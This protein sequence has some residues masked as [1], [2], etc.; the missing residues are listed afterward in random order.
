MKKY[1]ILILFTFPLVS[2]EDFLKEEM[3]STITQDYFESEK[4]LE[5]L[6]VGSYNTL[7]WKY[8][9]MEGPFMFETGIDIAEP[10]DNNWATISPATW[11]PSGDAGGYANNL[12]GYYATQLLGGYPI[13][14]DCNKAIEII[15]EKA[16]GKFATNAEY[17]NTRLSEVYFLRAWT[18]YMLVTQLGDVPMPLKSN[19][20][21]PGTFNFP[22]ST[23][24]AIYAQIISDLRFAHDHLPLPGA[25][26]RGRITRYAASHFLAKLYLQREQAKAYQT[27]RNEDGTV[28]PNSP[29]AHLGLLYKGKGVNDLDSAK[30]YSTEVID[31][32]ASKNGGAYRGLASDYWD[33]FK[34][35]RGDWSNEDNAEIIL[36]A[37]YGNNLANGRYG[38]RTT[39]AFTCDY[40]NA[41]WNLPSKT[42]EYGLRKGTGFLATDWGYD[43]FTDKINDSRFEK[44]FQIEYVSASFDNATLTDGPGLAYTNANNKSLAWTAEE[45]AYF[46]ANIQPEYDRTS[47]A[48]RKAVVGQRK[49]GTG[50]LGLVFLENTK[51]TAID[52]LAAVAQPYVLYPRWVK[53]GNEYFYRKTGADRLV[54]NT[55]LLIGR[56]LRPSSRKFIDPNR[57]TVDNHFGTRDVAIFRL[58]ETYLIRAEVF[59]RL[60][61]YGNAINDINVLR[62]RAAYKAGEKRAEVIARLYP[63]YEKLDQSE[64][65][66][67]YAALADTY[68][69]IKVDASYWDGGSARSVA[70]NYPPEANT[71]AKRFIH[72]IYNEMSREFNSEQV[73]YE[74]IH[75]AGIQL[76]RVVHHNQL[77]SP[78]AGNWPVSDNPV[79][80]NGQNGNGKGVFSAKNTF[81]PFPQSFMNMLTDE[82]GSPLSSSD[83]LK[84]YQNPGYN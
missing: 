57:S 63:G 37:S 43:V 9:F 68:S 10:T 52:Y 47:W 19:N 41:A 12:M 4:G 84:N 44:S 42:W 48:G 22:K 46:N 40:T 21:L 17:A 61:D 6:V 2:C 67:P 36:Q 23:S 72:F 77:A 18:Y 34:T 3:V 66:F 60:G 7:R 32:Y 1:L 53:K 80:G 15:K 27:Y 14:N 49:V 75:H 20:S 82:N 8:G 64:R 76:E 54:S 29:D 69:K 26:E 78:K 74:G 33:L 83:K 62:A 38:M 28:N 73:V 51:E 16:P 5:E 35:K 30:I 45:A 13:I 39:A 50:D 11:A 70:E 59:G 79:N 58:A 55:G 31:A 71:T 56:T 24:A 81:K 25:T 65:K